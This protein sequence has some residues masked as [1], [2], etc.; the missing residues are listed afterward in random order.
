[1]DLCVKYR[2]INCLFSKPPSL[3]F[4][5]PNGRII[6][7]TLCRVAEILLPFLPEETDVCVT[8]TDS[9]SSKVSAQSHPFPPLKKKKKDSCILF[10]GQFQYFSRPRWLLS[11]KRTISLLSRARSNVSLSHWITQDVAPT[12][13]LPKSKIQTL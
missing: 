9:K 13:L 6:T 4:T 8:G 10:M 11:W 7:I 1:M 12:S 5:Q 2:L 3:C